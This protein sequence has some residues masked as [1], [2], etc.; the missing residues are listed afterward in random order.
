MLLAIEA[1][2]E[3]MSE[4]GATTYE[5]LVNAGK[6]VRYLGTKIQQTTP[7]DPQTGQGVPY[8]SRVHGVQMAEVEVDMETGALDIIRM[9]AVVDAGTIINPIVVEGQIEGGLDMGAGMALREEYVHGETKDWV[10]YKFP[11]IRNSFESNIILVETPR[12]KGPEGAV[13][14]GEFVMLPT[15]AAIMNAMEDA[16]GA[17]VQHLPATPPKVLAAL[18]N[19]RGKA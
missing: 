10:T 1:L 13:G 18:V 11:T 19:C 9:T 8:E 15:A 7:L 14:V 3:A 4:T 16:T 5:E 12:I 2:R 17:R 6:P